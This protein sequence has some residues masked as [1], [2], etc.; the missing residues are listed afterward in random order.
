V[1][2]NVSNV[3][4]VHP[5]GQGYRLATRFA[6]F[7]NLPELMT[8]YKSFAD[9]ITM[10]DLKAQ[11]E[12]EGKRFPVP[13]VKGGKPRTSWPSAAR[14]RSS[15]SASRSRSLNDDGSPKLNGEG[16]QVTRGRRAPSS[17]RIENLKNVKDPREDNM[18]KITND[19]RKAGLDFRLVDPSAPDFPGRS[20]T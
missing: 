9:V 20:R 7:V 12:A 5:S 4:E 15:S 17:T 19:A 2:G 14:S 10:K 11:S 8:L 16:A 13:N 1:F 3:Y 6:K 18:L